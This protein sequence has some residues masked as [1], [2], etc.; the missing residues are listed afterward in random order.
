MNLKFSN[1]IAITVWKLKRKKIKEETELKNK[2]NI[3]EQLKTE[4]NIFC[5]FELLV[6]FFWHGNV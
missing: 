3:P 4:T 2:T 6:I 5:R 1:R